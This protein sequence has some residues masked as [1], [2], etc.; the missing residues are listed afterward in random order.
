MS[1]NLNG[2]VVEVLLIQNKGKTTDA[3][4]ELDISTYLLS[5]G[6][7]SWSIDDNLT[8]LSLGNLSLSVTDDTSNTVW[9]FLT[10]GIISS[11]GILPPWLILTVDGVQRFIGL[12]KESP[13]R[14][15]DLG[16]LEI[17]INAVDWSSMLESQRIT[18]DNALSRINDFKNGPAFA[19]GP[20]ITAKSVY[21]KELRRNHDRTT[22]AVAAS[23]VNNFSAGDWV[24]FNNYSS[25]SQYNQKYPVLATAIHDIGGLGTMYC[26]Y[27]GG[28]FWWSENP[29]D[30]QN[31]GQT[32]SLNR[33]YK[34]TSTALDTTTNLPTF[35]AAEDFTI[36]TAGITPKTSIKLTYVDG[37]QPGD[38]LNKLTNIASPNDPA[39]S[40]T[41]VDVD[42]TTNT[43]YLDAPL[44]NNLVNGVTSFQISQ[45]SLQDSVL[46]PLMSLVNKSVLG[47]ATIDYS[48]YQP[49]VLPSPCFSFISPA[50]PATQNTHTETLSGISDLQ[51]SLTGY[52]LLGTAGKAWTGLPSTGWDTLGTFTKNVNWTEQVSVAPSYIMPYI[53]VPNGTESTVR[54]QTRYSGLNRLKRNLDIDSEDIEPSVATVGSPVYKYVY[55]Y[56]NLRCY[57]FTYNPSISLTVKVWNGTTWS[58]LGGF[59]TAGIGNNVRDIVP[60]KDTTSSVSSGYGL[61]ALCNDGT[62]KTI[63]ANVSYSVTIAGDDIKDANGNLQVSLKQT[64]NGIYYFTPTGYGK[65]WIASGALKSKWVKIL[66]DSNNLN[67][68]QT[69]TPILNTFIYSNNQLITLAKVSYKTS[70]SDER[71]IDDTYLLRLNKDIQDTATDSV[72]SV[73]FIVKN[74]PRAT[75]AVKSPV[76]EDIFGFMGSR[77][78]QI[79][80]YLPDTVERFTSINQTASAIIEFVCSMTNSVAIPMTTGNLKLYSRGFNNTPT[81]INIDQVSIKESRWNKH[82]ADCVVIKGKD[83]KSG[84]AVST[85]QL[86]G[87]TISYS[88][89]IYIR[90]SSQAQAIAESYLIFFEKPRREVEQEWFSQSFPAAWEYLSPMDIIT[91]NGGSTQYYLTSMNHNLETQTATVTLLEVV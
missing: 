13:V 34:T 51:P 61:L 68:L 9:N 76:S 57:Q 77:V 44:N 30:N 39:F 52:E 64:S 47:L 2:R 37:L 19:T 36:A 82:L 48:S 78:F 66:D 73:D 40:F 53:T 8:K 56:S 63:L 4:T 10:T 81:N 45:A 60:F 12:I 84:V 14:T 83:S 85:T 72:L 49:A 59:S 29:G 35:L 58:T 6:N 62:I 25:F 24:Y 54:G 22:V 21:N 86:A 23:E 65:I 87:L 28:G 27:L 75:M 17:S 33:V 5:L 11:S 38:T 3:G 91:I 80:K 79:T 42:V 7:I 15:Q 70:L 50:S 43:V 32:S 26:L 90:N 71:F 88:N 1:I 16:T 18:T 31:F 74:I 55:D 89:D 46:V 69:I 67:Q 20:T 41:I